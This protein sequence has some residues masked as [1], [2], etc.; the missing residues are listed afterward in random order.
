MRKD[1]IEIGH[2]TVTLTPE[3][4]EAITIAVVRKLRE[5]GLMQIG[6]NSGAALEPDKAKVK[7]SGESMNLLP[8]TGYL[9]LPEVLQFIPVCRT[10]WW[11]GIK[12]GKYPAG[13]K[14]SVRCTAWRAE[15]IRKLIL[16]LGEED[17]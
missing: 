5:Q 12:A 6:G 13:V 1:S 11:K 14:L 3:S 15:D 8:E 2:I 17:S 4:I 7:L 16:R 10:I 9:R